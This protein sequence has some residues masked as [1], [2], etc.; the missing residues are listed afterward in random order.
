[1]LQYEFMQ[2]AF[3]AG[4]LVAL[5]TSLAGNFLVLKRF[6]QMGDS[7]SHTA[8][9][10]VA[11]SLLFNF[12]PTIGAIISTVGFAIVLE[13]FK[14]KFKRFE[15]ISLALVSIT[16][17]GLASVLFGIL[18]SSSNL[19]SF[20]FGSIVA[21][22]NEDVWIIFAVCLVTVTFIAMFRKRLI[23]ATFDEVSAKVS[24]INTKLLDFLLSIV[25]A[26]IIAV[27]IKIV[28]GLL[29]S[30]LIVFPTA[31]AMRFS[32]NF[33]MLQ[34]VSLL[35]SLIAVIVGLTS[36]Y[37]VDIP[38]GGATVLTFLVIFFIAELISV[39]GKR[40]TATISK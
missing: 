15:E 4:V 10:G 24:G 17:L 19:M 23:F 11:A 26:T 38:P 27:S 35:V 30:S 33:K 39:A 3:L 36:S 22:G 34:I 14:S 20:L 29:I 5:M 8:I 25:S 12:S 7:L 9:V 21:I 18:K 16:A 32:K 40:K 13:Y 28:G 37:Y 1:M 2:R 31:I 6:S